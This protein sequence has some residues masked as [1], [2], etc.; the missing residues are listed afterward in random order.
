[1]SSIFLF[2]LIITSTYLYILIIISLSLSFY[3]FPYLSP[4]VCGGV[5]E[6]EGLLSLVVETGGAP[7]P[8]GRHRYQARRRP[9]AELLGAEAADSVHNLSV[10]TYNNISPF[11]YA[12]VSY[13]K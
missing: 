4:A 12:Y 3:L 8:A 13:I 5:D 11:K 1:M 10:G 9:H 2:L 7:P 6:G